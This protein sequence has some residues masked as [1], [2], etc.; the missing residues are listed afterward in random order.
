MKIRYSYTQYPLFLAGYIAFCLAFLF[1]GGSVAALLLTSKSENGQLVFTSSSLVLFGVGVVTFLIFALFFCA[2][3]FFSRV[4]KKK[5]AEEDVYKE[6][7]DSGELAKVDLT[8]MPSLKDFFRLSFHQYSSQTLLT[9]PPFL[10]IIFILVVISIFDKGNLWALITLGS[11]FFIYY[12]F[13]LVIRPFLLRNAY[14][15]MPESATIGIHK[16]TIRLDYKQNERG[17]LIKLPYER[18]VKNYSDSD[19]YLFRFHVHGRSLFLL[20]PKDSVGEEGKA[21]LEK[22]ISA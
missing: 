15:R 14:K 7:G 2:C 3:F 6:T 16:K 17:M 10:T 4:K 19:T 21:V 18:L 11:I 1:F 13:F 8:I 20:I 12:L 22:A 5:E 9:L